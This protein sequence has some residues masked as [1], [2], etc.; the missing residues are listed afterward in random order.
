MTSEPAS[1][2]QISS[3]HQREDVRPTTSDLTCNRPKYMADLRWN[4][5][6][7]LEPSCLDAVTSPSRCL[8]LRSDVTSSY[9]MRNIF[10]TELG[11][12]IRRICE[13]EFTPLLFLHADF[14]FTVPVIL[15]NCSIFKNLQ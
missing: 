11:R 5:V 14:R 3:P 13:Y 2:L 6:S 7:N 10:Q 8:K 9:K 12:L 1:P 15:L 4:L